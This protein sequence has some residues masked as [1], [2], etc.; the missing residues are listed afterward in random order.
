MSHLSHKELNWYKFT[1]WHFKPNSIQNA[2]NAWVYNL[3]AANSWLFK[4]ISLGDN[5]NQFKE[6]HIQGGKWFCQ[7]WAKYGF[8]GYLPNPLPSC[9]IISCRWSIKNSRIAINILQ[10]ESREIEFQVNPYWQTLENSS[11]FFFGLLAF[12]LIKGS[13]DPNHFIFEINVG[14]RWIR[15]KTTL[16]LNDVNFNRFWVDW[17]LYHLISESL[18]VGSATFQH[19][20]QK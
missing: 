6:N 11:R 2:K 16:N 18:H 9:Q 17:E 13:S 14:K 10:S 5:L 3:S 7:K 1:N 15:H 20:F 4:I 8:L 12:R 19:W